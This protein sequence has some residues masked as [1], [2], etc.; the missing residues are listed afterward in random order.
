MRN[1]G[2][3]QTIDSSR[4]PRLARVPVLVILLAIL[5]C[6]GGAGQASAGELRA[7]ASVNANAPGA[8]HLS[9]QGDAFRLGTAAAPF[10]WSTTVADLDRDG[11]PDVA[12]ADRR[13]RSDGF[14]YTIEL[15][16][17]SARPQTLAF[18]SPHDSLTVTARD[19]DGDRDLDLVVTPALTRDVV[20]L[21]L[22]DGGGR[23]HR[24]ELAASPMQLPPVGTL[25]PLTTELEPSTA[26]TDGR[27]GDAVRGSTTTAFQRPAVTARI[28]RSRVFRSQLTRYLSLPLR[29]PPASLV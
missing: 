7:F 17:S 3:A 26:V 14:A 28:R 15:R 22:N 1:T 9:T 29:A 10:G 16:I 20:G 8:D 4:G 21:W 5:A 24:A 13:G 27:D 2:L 19:V 18:R 23:F 25:A 11:W 6:V 12:I